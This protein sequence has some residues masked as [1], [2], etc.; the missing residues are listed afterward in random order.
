MQ[1]NNT[2][3][4]S[5]L[6][7]EPIQLPETPYTV[8]KSDTIQKWID[9]K[10][11]FTM[12]KDNSNI[13]VFREGK[14]PKKF[15]KPNVVIGENVNVGY[16]LCTLVR[17]DVA[18]LNLKG[19]RKIKPIT[20][21]NW[22]DLENIKKNIGEPI[23]QIDISACYWIVAY[24][25]GFI[26]ERTYK[27][28]LAN[29]NYKQGRNT[30]LGALASPIEVKLYRYGECIE[31]IM[32]EKET[33]IVRD[34]IVSTVFDLSMEIYNRFSHDFIFFETDCFFVTTKVAEKVQKMLKD[35]QFNTVIKKAVIHDCVADNFGNVIIY[36]NEKQYNYDHKKNIINL[37]K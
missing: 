36:V 32:E 4:T 23:N 8:F 29:K 15:H 2:L 34:L 13:T 28:G 37:L 27:S 16:H 5:N 30:A 35:R 22:F 1:K 26:S 10:L 14:E 11:S 24:H 7:I 12:I 20:V 9:E 18:K 3:K 17:K 33:K 19:L 31:T 6:Q 21:A 25:K